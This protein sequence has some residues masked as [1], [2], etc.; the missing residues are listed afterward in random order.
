MQAKYCIAVDNVW[1]MDMRY[2]Y[3]L[4]CQP[5]I[6]N[7]RFTFRAIYSY[8]LQYNFPH[9]LHSGSVLIL[10]RKKQNFSIV[11]NYVSCYKHVEFA[12]AHVDSKLHN[13]VYSL[14]IFPVVAAAG[15]LRK[16]TIWFI[17]VK[18]WLK[19]PYKY[20]YY[21]HCTAKYSV[22]L[23]GWLKVFVAH[24]II[25]RIRIITKISHVLHLE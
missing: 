9:M 19:Q 10:L 3:N 4:T 22:N 16:S 13:K 12:K 18:K 5:W 6:L 20:C 17:F 24:I 7:E 15:Y 11:N 23:S 25:L 21:S 1:F 2:S 8:E 14:H